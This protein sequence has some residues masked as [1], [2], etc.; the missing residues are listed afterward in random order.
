MNARTVVASAW[1]LAVAGACATGCKRE[2][3]LKPST[4]PA[5]ASERPADRL[6]PGE[7]A[8]GKERALGLVLP[9]DMRLER[10]FDD[11]ASAR[12]RVPAE[13][14]ADYVRAR[15]E[16]PN[17]ELA[18]TRTIFPAAHPRGAPAGKMV[19]IEILRDV[20]TTVLTLRDVTPPP[21][22]T[23]L[24]EGERWRKAG[25]QP[26]KPFVPNAL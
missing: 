13:S 11:S 2:S 8:E 19:R 4:P 12:G 6:L 16:A 14:L 1:F 9:R 23:G 26:G 21:V 5:P 22:P 25:V 10:V 15:V 3:E 24:S 17:A 18:E 7:L 20:D